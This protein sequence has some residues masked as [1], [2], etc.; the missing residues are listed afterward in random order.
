MVSVVSGEWEE[1]GSE[2]G[3]MVS[4]QEWCSSE[5]GA[6]VSGKSGTTVSVSS[7]AATERSQVED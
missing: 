4:V 1:G 6:A 2:C 7:A 5:C 3:G